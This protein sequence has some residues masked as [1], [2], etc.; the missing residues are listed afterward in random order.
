MGVGGG[1]G[2]W[3]SD[4]WG[5]LK[6]MGG[7]AGGRV[8]KVQC[9]GC[10]S[11]FGGQVLVARVGGVEESYARPRSSLVLS[12]WVGV[13]WGVTLAWTKGRCDILVTTVLLSQ[14]SQRTIYRP[15]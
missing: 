9:N 15:V 13:G 3:A 11:C 12:V 7:G 14:G 4:A 10:I 2:V 5:E 1:A 6:T 8:V